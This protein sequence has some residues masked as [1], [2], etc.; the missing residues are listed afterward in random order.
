MITYIKNLKK[1]FELTHTYKATQIIMPFNYYE[2]LSTDHDGNFKI[3]DKNGIL[4]S[5]L[6]LEIII[7]DRINGIEIR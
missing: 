2:T 1:E 5:I 7:D 6:G 4:V 3:I